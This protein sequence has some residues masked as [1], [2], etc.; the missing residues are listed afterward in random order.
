[1]KRGRWHLEM[2]TWMPSL[3]MLCTITRFSRLRITIC[4]QFPTKNPDKSVGML[5]SILVDMYLAL[6][7]PTV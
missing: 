1:M 2:G 5:I 7:S 4:N 3:L 6:D